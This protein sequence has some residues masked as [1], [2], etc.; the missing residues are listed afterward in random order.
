MSEINYTDKTTDLYSVAQAAEMLNLS[1]GRNKF[2]KLLVE[3]EI[4]SNDHYPND[5]M[6]NHQLMVY[7]QKSIVKYGRISY[8][9]IPFF[10]QRGLTYISKFLKE[11]GII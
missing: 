3:Q 1:F 5:F 9:I 11:K 2:Y 4:L 10:T 7:R 6:S 8:S